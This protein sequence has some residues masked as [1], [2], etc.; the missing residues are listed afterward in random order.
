MT[1][2]TIDAR[3]KIAREWKISKPLPAYRPPIRMEKKDFSCDFFNQQY[4]PFV[5]LL[6]T[7]EL[8]PSMI[9]SEPMIFMQKA[10]D[11]ECN[12]NFLYESMMRDFLI[13]C[14]KILMGLLIQQSVTKSALLHNELVC[15]AQLIQKRSLS[16]SMVN[17]CDMLL[18]E[19][20]DAYMNKIVELID[21]KFWTQNRTSFDLNSSFIKKETERLRL[22]SSYTFDI[23]A[24]SMLRRALETAPNNTVKVLHQWAG[25]NGVKIE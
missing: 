16:S 23:L 18:A 15:A 5:K 3:L 17:F 2:K 20:V 14:Q 4:A 22:M 10:F 6:E 1:E 25:E 12:D 24:S 7:Y 11:I 9:P 21:Q 8:N 19:C 13:S